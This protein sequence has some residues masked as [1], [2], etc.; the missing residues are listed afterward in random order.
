MSNSYQVSGTIER[1]FDARQIT[2]KFSVREFVVKTTDGQYPQMVVLQLMNEAGEK[3]DSHEVGDEV[4]VHF[5]LRGRASKK[6]GRFW[7]TLAAWKIERAGE[8]AKRSSASD[9]AGFDESGPRGS[10]Y[11]GATA[12]DPAA[13]SGGSTADFDDDIPF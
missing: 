3:I 12:A 1:I 5:N 8:S 10:Q 13:W 7:N 4:T 9:G 11:K 6:D 2:E